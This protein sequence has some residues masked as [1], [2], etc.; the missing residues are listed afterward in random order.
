MTTTAKTWTLDEIKSL[1]DSNK[2]FVCKAIVKIFE[3]Q[4]EDEKQA[5]ATGHSNGIGYN[6]SDAFIMSK[7]AKFYMEKGFLTDKQLAIGQK[8]IKKYAKQ[9]TN[10]ANEH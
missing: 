5:D 2:L 8:K 3:R 4:T 10:I 7:F 1:L 6:G 9:L